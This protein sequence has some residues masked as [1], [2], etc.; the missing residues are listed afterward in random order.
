MHSRAPAYS[1]RGASRWI[2]GSRE[3]PAQILQ[4]R[5]SA[6]FGLLAC[7]ASCRWVFYAQVEQRPSVSSLA[8]LQLERHVL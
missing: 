7:R 8:S 1:S 5:P 3:A 6:C 4:R 2:A